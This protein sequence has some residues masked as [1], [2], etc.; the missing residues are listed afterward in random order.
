M[1]YFVR[2]SDGVK[3]FMIYSFSESQVILS[4]DVRFNEG[5]MYLVKS[6]KTLDLGSDGEIVLQTN[7]VLKVHQ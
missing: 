5:T 4:R 1:G 7:R 3:G 6:T 2:Y